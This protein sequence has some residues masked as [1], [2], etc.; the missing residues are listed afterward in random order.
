MATLL[1]GLKA[2]T[3]LF[4]Q[5]CAWTVGYVDTHSSSCYHALCSGSP[6]ICLYM[7][8]EYLSLTAL[9]SFTRKLTS[10]LTICCPSNIHDYF[11][12]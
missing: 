12:T 1:Y 3:Q 6:F 8:V 10:C 9:L 11:L 4:L 7:I 5:I 2:S